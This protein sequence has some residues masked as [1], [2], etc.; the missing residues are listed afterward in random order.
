MRKAIRILA[1]VFL[2]GLAGPVLAQADPTMHQIYETAQSG[3]LTQAQ[4]MMDQVLRDHPQS[5]KAHYVA[6]ELYAREG[7]LA[8]ARQ[9][10]ST[11]QTLEPGLPFVRPEALGSLQ[12][13]LSGR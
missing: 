8:S 10:L 9:E 6:A 3:N 13:Q 2:A 5:A 11:A 7:N 1:L 4:H 12:R